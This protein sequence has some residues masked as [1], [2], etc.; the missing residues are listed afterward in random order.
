MNAAVVPTQRSRVLIVDDA[1]ENLRILG[2]TLRDNYTIMFAKNGRDALRLVEGDTPPDIVLMDVVMPGMNGYEACRRL[3]QSPKTSAIPV[4][5][6]TA[7]DDGVDEATGLSLGAQDYIKKP[8]IASLV[9][10]RVDSAVEL[11]RHR[12]HLN[13]LVKERTR[14]LALTQEATIHSMANLAEWRDPETGAHIKRTQSYVRSLAQHLSRLPRYAP[15]LTPEFLDMLYLSAPLHDVGKVAIPD[16]VL[17]KPGRLT[18]EEFEVM[19]T[20][21]TRGRDVLAS[22]EE[23]LGQNSFL[24]MSQDIA[25]CHHERWDGKGYP[26]GIG[27]E[28]IPL[29]A[30]LMSLA[31]V[32]DALRSKRVYKP[33]MSHEETAGIIF[34]GKGTQFDPALIDAFDELQPEFQ[35]IAAR[36]AE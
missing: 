29:S 17:H 20:H 14:Q 30:R 3:K 33:G 32:Y 7:Q 11:K 16:A 8:F 5:F 26:R 12:D 9:R 1:A 4:I 25:Y 22:T 13:E 10:N 35:N 18:E 6:V 24:N 36:Y 2:E 19:K 15:E 34:E 31:D 28:E 21:T 27:K 23:F